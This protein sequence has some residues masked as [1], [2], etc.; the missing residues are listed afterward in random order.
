MAVGERTFDLYNAFVSTTQ[1]VGPE[2]ISIVQQFDEVAAN[3]DG[4]IVEAA[5]DRTRFSATAEL[6]CQSIIDFDDII[7]LFE[8]SASQTVKGEGKDVSD[9]T[10][11]YLFT[12]NRMKLASARL[13]LGDGGGGGYAQASFS[14]VNS[15]AA[16]SNSPDDEVVITNPS[17]TVTH[18]SSKRGVRIVSASFLPSGGSAIAPLAVMGM[19]LNIQGQVALTAGDDE[20]GKIAEITGYVMSGDLTFKDV[21]LATLQ[22]V[23]QRLLAATYGDLTITYRQQGGGSDGTI[24]LRQLQFPGETMTLQARQFGGNALRFTQFSLLNGTEKKLASDGT[25]GN[26]L[27]TIA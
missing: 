18:S 27:L 3:N 20:Y 12:L 10:K 15:A 5:R 13:T 23:G 16:A 26:N 8:T 14:L 9:P 25:P 11:S 7:A 4:T 6:T 1:L 17:K 21:T 19:N 22:T 24:T 2:Q